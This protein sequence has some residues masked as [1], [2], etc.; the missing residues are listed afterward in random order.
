M[1]STRKIVIDSIRD[2]PTTWIFEHYLSL[3]EKLYGQEVVIKSIFNPNEKTPSMTVYP[4]RRTGKYKFKDFSSGCYG[5]GYDL[6]K[7]ILNLSASEAVF[8]VLKDYSDHVNNNEIIKEEIK[9]IAKYTVSDYEAR[10]WNTNDAKYWTSFGIG[11][12]ILEHYNVMPLSWYKIKKEEDEV[13]INST[14]IY[15]YFREDGLI[16]KI[17][18]PKSETR[19]FFKVRKHI[20]GMEQLTYQKPNLAILSSLKDMMS[21]MQLGFKTI[22]CIAPD[23][24]NTM[25]PEAVM[26]DL[27]SKYQTVT[28]VFDNDEAGKKGLLRYKEKYGLNGF[29][30]NLEKD[31]S[32]CVAKHGKERTKNELVP[33]LTEC[34]HTCRRCPE[35]SI[36]V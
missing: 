28:V 13:C 10:S 9:S 34:I 20:Q 12:K 24:E 31:I 36:S 11:S 22:E 2:V 14:Y 6:V 17:Y 33:L 25:I 35:S 1:I 8:R 18:Q 5:D 16:Y 4:D 29:A 30:L 32:D 26:W 3:Q 15:G 23:S 21:F 7:Q 27:I 19:K